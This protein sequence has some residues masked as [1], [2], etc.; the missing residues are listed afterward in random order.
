MCVCVTSGSATKPSSDTGPRST[1]NRNLKGRGCARA[2]IRDGGRHSKNAIL[3]RF[4]HSSYASRL[5]IFTSALSGD[6]ANAFVPKH[7]PGKTPCP[8][9]YVHDSAVLVLALAL[10]DYDTH[11]HTDSN[12]LETRWPQ[13]IN[14]IYCRR[15]RSDCHN[16]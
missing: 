12:A 5:L 15:R 4:F 13:S 1:E 3:L 10:V 7:G 16:D 14:I 11:S 8:A 2:P 9:A 6:P